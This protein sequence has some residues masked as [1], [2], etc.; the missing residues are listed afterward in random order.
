[1][2]KRVKIIFTAIYSILKGLHVTFKNMLRKPVTLDYPYK[3][4]PMT[5]SFRGLVDLVP[6]KC[7]ICYQCVRVCPTAALDLAHDVDKDRK[8]TI[9]KFTFNAELC[10][11]CGL[12]EEICPTKAMFLNKM[13]EVSYDRHED[14]MEVDLMS[15]KK[16]E[17]IK[18]T[19]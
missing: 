11:Y 2:L 14:M 18:G 12:C 6:E 4:R 15:A 13:Y 16:Y 17:Q 1:M 3:K 8:K 10:C 9:I 19:A 5:K 7:V